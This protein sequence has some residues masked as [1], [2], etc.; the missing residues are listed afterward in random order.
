MNPTCPVYQLTTLVEAQ[1]RA[2]VVPVAAAISYEDT[3][4]P[5]QIPDA[6]RVDF[7][8]DRRVG[9]KFV[10][11]I[12]G[13]PYKVNGL[14][15]TARASKIIGVSVHLSAQ[16]TKEGADRHDHVGAVDELVDAVCCAAIEVSGKERLHVEFPFDGNY[17]PTPND[18]PLEIGARYELRFGLRV[19]VD[20]VT[21]LIGGPIVPVVTTKAIRENVREISSGPGP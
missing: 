11:A 12:T 5:D 13:G 4:F 16:S 7:R 21:G 14:Q 8:R 6:P 18:A 15:K 9:D 1:L 3:R 17:L 10:P 2:R 20:A 19:A